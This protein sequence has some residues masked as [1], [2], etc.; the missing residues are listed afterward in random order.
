MCGIAGYISLEGRPGSAAVVRRMTDAIAHRG[1]DGEGAFVEGSLA[2]GHRRLA[3]ID[4]SDG[5]QQ[6]MR[7]PDQRF[8]ITYNGEIYNHAELK[9]E[10]RA[11]GRRFQS[12]SDTEVLLQAIAEWGLEKALPRL[13]GMFAFALWDAR[14]RALYLSRDRFGVKPLYWCRSKNLVLFGSEVK[15]ILAHPEVETALDPDGLAEYVAFQNFHTDRTLFRGV[16]TLPAGSCLT[17]R[18]DSGLV[19]APVRYHALR[20]SKPDQDREAEE[21]AP[22]FDFLFRQAVSRQTVADVELGSYL[23]G[24]LDSGA[25]TAVAASELS[26]LRTF[27]CGFDLSSASGLEVYFDERRDAEMMSALW[28]TEHYEMV[29]KAGDMERIIPKLVWHLEEPRIGQCYPN[30]YVAGLA[31]KFNKAVFAGTGSDE[32]FGGYPWRYESALGETSDETAERTYRQW[33]RLVPEVTHAQL[34]APLRGQ[35]STTTPRDIFDAVFERPALGASVEDRLNAVL[36]YEAN[37]FLHGLLVMEDKV[38]MAH[39][40]ECRVPFLDNDL[41]DFASTLAIR[42]KLRSVGGRRPSSGRTSGGKQLLRRAFASFMPVE[43]VNREKQGFSAPDAS[44]FRGESIDFVR[45]RIGNPRARIY[46]LLDY[47]VAAP[48]LE[49]HWSGQRNHRLLIW[50]LIYLEQAME[51]WHLA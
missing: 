11:L 39:G 29:L 27:T 34:L 21:L 37:T 49:E 31:S 47:G 9:V 51:T 42:H 48:L 10:L 5:G 50:S 1:P 24:G 20:F 30:F 32:L 46:G 15:A 25:I 26:H 41:A 14:D 13:N 43:I 44:W 40:L 33:L 38:A 35:L 8:T 2:L 17:I 23:S 7:T 36:T 22:Y 3:I 18:P 45:A 4:L 6:P 16:Q 28:K 19:G 12:A